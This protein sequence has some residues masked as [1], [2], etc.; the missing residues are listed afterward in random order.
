MSEKVE[1]YVIVPFE[2]M[3]ELMQK[4][5]KISNAMMNGTH[6]KGSLGEFVTE[7]EAKAALSKGT[8]WFWNKRKAGELKGRKAGNQWYYKKS[9]ILKLIENGRSS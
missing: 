5:D 9:E 4:V 1:K 2:R 8:T 7:K 6:D 3:E